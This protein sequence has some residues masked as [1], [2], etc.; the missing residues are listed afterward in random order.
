MN[1]RFFALMLAL[2]AIFGF[3]GFADDG[4]EKPGSEQVENETP[5]TQEVEVEEAQS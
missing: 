2:T 1:K 3:Q 5:E 4:E